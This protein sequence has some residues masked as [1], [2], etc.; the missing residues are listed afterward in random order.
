VDD[1][2]ARPRAWTIG[3][4][5]AGSFALGWA[6]GRYRR[7][8]LQAT[9]ASPPEPATGS[10]IDQTTDVILVVDDDERIRYASRSARLMLGTALLHGLDL[11]DLV[12][13]AERDIARRLL[14]HVRD[15][16]DEGSAHADLTIRSANGRNIRTEVVCSD[17]R[18]EASVGGLVLTLRDVTNQRRLEAELTQQLYSDPVTGLPNRASFH[19]ATDRALASNTGTVGVL[20]FDLD[21][22]RLVN[23]GLGRTMGDSALRAA[24]DRLRD[25]AGPGTLTA[26]LDGDEFA[27]L[28]PDEAGDDAA[29]RAAERVIA[30]FAEPVLVGSEPVRCQVSMGVATV[31]RGHDESEL[32]RHADIALDAVKAA[33]A[34]GWRRYEPSMIETVQYRNDLRAALGSAVDDGSLVV[35]Y[36]PIVALASRRTAGFEAL[37][38]WQHPTRGLLPPS[39]FIGIAEESNLIHAIGT[40]V[41]TSAIRTWRQWQRTNAATPY[42]SVNV[43]VRQ[44]RSRGFADTVHRIVRDAG[45]PAGQLVLEI[46]ESLLLRDDDQVWEDLRRLRDWGI[47]I[48]IDDF[49]TGYSAL[50]Y[51][52]QVPLDIVK[53]DRLFVGTMTGSARQRALLAGIVDLARSLGLQTVAEGI[54]TTEQRDMCAAIGC[55]YGQGFLFARSMSD[56]DAKAWLDAE[57]RTSI[58]A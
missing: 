26:R 53:L 13:P 57:R 50:G 25:A 27:V 16:S 12:D 5:A 22:F 30:A 41:L 23:E 18:A 55:T 21:R 42:V 28:V 56:V 11:I 9:T 14:R 37:V 8:A 1:G 54:E 34:G 33:G 15:G 40:H 52:R 44:F 32:L 35:E 31:A 19:D 3:A 58:R 17:L 45:V 2:F 43:S 51:L 49:G 4:V 10:L 36:Q 39:E 24:G 29:A 48:A 38:R 20:L 46:T 7:R 6:S 47:R